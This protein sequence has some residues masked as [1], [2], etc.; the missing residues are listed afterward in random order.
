MHALHLGFGIGSFLIP[1]IANPFL[2]DRSLDSSNSTLCHDLEVTTK[3]SS[4]L[5]E[6][7]SLNNISAQDDLRRIV[8]ESRIEYAYIIAAIPSFLFALVFLGFQ[9][10]GNISSSN[11][12]ES[13]VVAKQPFKKMINPATCANGDFCFGI[14]IFILMFLQFFQVVGGERLYGK[15]IRTYAVDHVDFS[16]N[17]GSYVDTVFW[18]GFSAGRFAGFVLGKWIPIRVMLLVES[19]GIFLSTVILNALS[20]VNPKLVLW[21]ST[22]MIGFFTGPL[23][24]TSMAWT[25]YHLKLTGLGITVNCLGGGVGGMVYLW[26]MGYFYE[27]YGPYTFPYEVLVYGIL[28]LIISLAL[29][30]VG[31]RKGGR[32]KSSTDWV[33]FFI[34]SLVP[35]S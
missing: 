21:I 23:F 17:S 28:T 20:S 5:C 1:L 25:D 27:Y 14:T 6:S 15:F 19:S 30:F 24:P 34:C 22:G 7:G 8:A 13:G 35:W 26:I 32:F 29:H 9:F 10:F 33:S 2:A 11:L 31:R 4:S 12:E 16:K 3:S 18:I